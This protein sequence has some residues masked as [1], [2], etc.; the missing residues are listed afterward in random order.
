MRSKYL[1]IVILTSITILA[2]IYFIKID[3]ENLTEVTLRALSFGFEN[4]RLDNLVSAAEELNY[5]LSKEGKD[6]RV[7]IET[8]SFQGFWD[9]YREFFVSEFES[10]NGPDIY[11]TGHENIAW[12][13]EGN[14]IVN[15]DQLKE[16]T[17]YSDVFNSLWKSTRWDGHVWGALQDAE[18]ALVFVNV[19]KLKKLGWSE[20]EIKDLP[21][22]VIKGEFTLDDMSRLAKEAV[23]KGIVKWGIVHRPVNGQMFYL[24]AENFEVQRFDE[25]E[26]KIIVNKKNLIKSLE[27]FRSITQEYMITPKDITSNTWNEVYEYALEDKA[28]FYFGGTY[29]MFDFIEEAGAK[30]DKIMGKFDFMLIPTAK[31][32]GKPVTISHPLIYT[33]SSKCKNKELAIRLLEI[34]ADAKYQTKHAIETYH[35]PV[36]RSGAETKEFRSNE[37]LNSVM[38]M[39]DYTTFLPNDEKYL[40]YSQIY[41]AAIK[42]VETGKLSPEDAA[43]KMEEELKKTFKEKCIFEY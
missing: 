23:D 10:N 13:A 27:Y 5:E 15:L 4:T 34:V 25:Y 1:L 40:E 43:N 41:F 12:L 19:D 22:R 31:K 21:D 32:P 30:Y 11:I 9:K 39:L 7:K 42:N 16:S 29:S 14:Y 17:A 36:N 3:D 28:L 18:V 35:L 8:D 37:Y 6:V 33:I 26:N 24:I 20:Q 38:Y 2:S